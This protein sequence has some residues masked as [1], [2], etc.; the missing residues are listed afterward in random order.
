L[1]LATLDV[2]RGVAVL[3]IVAVNIAGFAGPVIATLTP[4]LPGPAS[5]A[6][7]WAFA[8]VL[9]L[10]EGK[11]RALF[12]LLFGASM[13]LFIER[14]EA[15]GRNG[16]ALQL[17]RLGW[18]AVF[19]YAHSMLLWWGDI[20]FVY[21]LC[22]M[23]ALALRGLTVRMQL[24]LGLV[25]FTLYAAFGAAGGWPLAVAEE[26]VR[27]GVA[28]AHEAAQVAAE[29]AKLRHN[30][31]QDIAQA[32]LGFWPMV[33]DKWANAATWPFVMTIA[34]FGETMPLMLIGMAL[35]RLGLPQGHWPPTRRCALWGLGLGGAMALGLIQWA[36]TRHFPP[37]AMGDWM[38]SWASGEHLLMALGYYSLLVRTAPHMPG[39][40]GQR[41]A[42]AGRMAFSNYLGTSLIMCAI[43]YGWGAGLFGKVSHAAQLGFVAGAWIVMLGWS[44]PWLDRFA[45][46]PLEWLWRSLVEGRMMRFR[47]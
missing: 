28:N 47:R 1:R 39:W 8:L 30:M 20:L 19:G 41:L 33:A 13:L 21:A 31:A 4:A 16:E 32:H 34:S 6:D 45:Q 2:I 7:G 14:A 26:H 12:S 23:V 10:F 22:G 5:R 15:S 27:L 35:Y 18:L 42:A 44:K 38:G 25:M 17:R 29:M 3:G 40:L 46:G 9:L 24:A 37:L 36:L 43:F 11:M